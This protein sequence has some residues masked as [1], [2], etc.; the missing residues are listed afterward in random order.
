[1]DALC[2]KPASTSCHA[3]QGACLRGTAHWS[4]RWMDVRQAGR[5]HSCS[6]GEHEHLFLRSPALSVS[7]FLS[8]LSHS[9]PAVRSAVPIEKANRHAQYKF[10]RLC[11]PS[12]GLMCTSW[13]FPP[14]SIRLPTPLAP[15]HPFPCQRFEKVLVQKSI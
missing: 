2:F 4:L 7:C 11:V 13:R 10:L 12:G 14:V 6:P 9:P 8:A 5:C 3:A 15:A 1:M